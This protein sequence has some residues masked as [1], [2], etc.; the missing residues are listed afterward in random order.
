[1]CLDTWS[2]VG[3]LFGK[4]ME[5]LGGAALLGEI[6]SLRVGLDFFIV[7]L[8]FLPDPQLS[9]LSVWIKYNQTTSCSYIYPMFPTIMD[10]NP[11]EHEPK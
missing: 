4:A 1:M 11:L 9:V 6:F 2:P 7:S 10:S 8:Y 3:V 5:S